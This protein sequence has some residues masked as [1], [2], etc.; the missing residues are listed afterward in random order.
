MI[1]ARNA[2][3]NI[4]SPP[5]GLAR[6]VAIMG[7]NQLVQTPYLKFGKLF[8]IARTE[9]ER[10]RT[11]QRLLLSYQSDKKA[12][13]PLS[14][15]VFGPPGSGKSF[16]VKELARAVFSENVPL[17]E[18][19]LSQFQEPS[20]LHGL[21]HQ[22]RDYVMRGKLPVVFWDE[23]DSQNLK[24]LQF[25]LAPMQDG[26]F[27]D[28]QI[29]HPI[30]KCVFV[31]AGGT[32]IRFDDFGVPKVQ[33]DGDGDSGDTAKSQSKELLEKQERELKVL[34]VPDFKSRL[35]GFLDV[36]GPNRRDSNDLTYPVRR[37]LMLRFH[38]GI[39]EKAHLT[40]DSGLL[41]AHDG[42]MQARMRQGWRLGANKDIAKREHHL[43]VPYSELREQIEKKQRFEQQQGKT[44]KKTID[45]EV[46]AEKNKDRDS[47]RNYIAIIA[48]TAF[49]IECI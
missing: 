35:A 45:Q 32:E 1:V 24:W 5:W 46:A 22:V 10:M 19:N 6:R 42:W 14:I 31:F 29:T 3:R 38:L 12:D 41:S 25:L 36:L 9:I 43:L 8:T 18:F 30:G 47:V 20:E 48:Q 34:K 2:E 16:G 17:L 7:E 40:I 27:Q 13:K 11:L 49:K 21:F 23:F 37:A 4:Q 44:P 28:G 26:A 33:R 39:A 15:A